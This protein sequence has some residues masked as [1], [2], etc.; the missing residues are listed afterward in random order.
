MDWT[1]LSPLDTES[2]LAFV[3]KAVS[4]A[5]GYVDAEARVSHVGLRC[6]TLEEW[7]ALLELAEPLGQGFMTYKPDGRPIPFIK[8]AAPVVVGGDV[9][10]YL[11]L[12]A[13]KKVVVDEPRVVVVFQLANGDGK[14]M[15]QGG[16]D[17]RQ[18]AMHAEDFI[19]RDKDKVA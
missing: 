14:A 5:R 2:V 19:A 13:P 18:Q 15:L 9:L 3:G 4:D 16:Y 1:K 8:L 6:Q 11:E 10:E 12:P 7:Q 17:I